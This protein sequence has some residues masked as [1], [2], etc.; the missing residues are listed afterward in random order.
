MFAKKLLYTSAVL[1]VLSF[2]TSCAQNISTA[3]PQ[4][5]AQSVKLAKDEQP[6]APKIRLK[7]KKAEI[8]VAEQDLNI[9]LNSILSLSNEKRLQETKMHL[10]P[11]NM[12]KVEGIIVQK[13][14]LIEKP[15]RL[16]FTVEGP[17]TVMPKNVIKFEA[18]KVKVASI[19]V[20]A[21]M[22]VIGLELTNITKFKDNVG[23]IELSGNNIMLVVEKFTNDA[24][25]EGQIKSLQTGDKVLTVFF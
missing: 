7:I 24:I 4:I 2:S 12:V 22:D 16:P 23:R 10:L 6:V 5:V 8:D 18:A 9:Q 17:L 20:K 25:I 14:P 19:P 11:N 13:L 3:P 15:L 1:T 21:L